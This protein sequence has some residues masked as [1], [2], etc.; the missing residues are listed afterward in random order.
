MAE[1]AIIL[2]GALGREV[3]DLVKKYAWEVDL[4]GI[5]AHAH[6]L[7]ATIA[8]LVE[9]KILELQSTY[10]K[11]IVAYGDCGSYGALDTV[12]D[13]YPWVHR[14]PGPHCYEM[15][16]G[17]AFDDFMEAELGTFFLTDFL[18]RAFH[19][20]VIKGLGLDRFPELREEY[21][22]HYTRVVFLKQSSD[23][24]L[25]HLAEEIARYLGLPLEIHPTGY[26]PFETRLKALV[27]D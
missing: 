24:N 2:C 7:P 21:F 5:S 18:V 16:A 26:G 9:Q 19:G 17:P 15:Y 14:L 3:S 13:R 6:L 12:L 4:Y 25:D 8:P 11:I 20:S 22:R 10:P 23:L 1:K 27:E